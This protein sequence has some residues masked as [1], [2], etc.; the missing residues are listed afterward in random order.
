M[1]LRLLP[2][3]PWPLHFPSSQCFWKLKRVSGSEVTVY[4]ILVLLSWRSWLGPKALF[5]LKTHQVNLFFNS[6]T[7]QFQDLDPR[8]GLIVCDTLFPAGRFSFSIN[9]ASR[10]DILLHWEDFTK[11]S[12]A[13]V[14]TSGKSYNLTLTY[15]LMEASHLL[16]V[17]VP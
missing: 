3:I 9:S 14:A 8:G 12:A 2:T 4:C 11:I 13:E 6:P 7:G 16:R 17:L 10:E 15:S 1:F 5:C